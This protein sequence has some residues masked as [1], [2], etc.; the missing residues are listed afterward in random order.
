[1]SATTARNHTT[2]VQC[3]VVSIAEKTISPDA[4]MQLG[5]GF[6]GSKTLLS[7]VELG[8]FTHLADGPLD[9]EMLRARMQLNRRSLPDFL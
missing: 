4:I 2:E 5:F 9:A 6:W 3:G 7:A 1:M 8:L